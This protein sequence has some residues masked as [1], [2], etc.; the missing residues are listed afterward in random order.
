MKALFDN[1]PRCSLTSMRN[2]LL[3][4]T[5]FIIDSV[6]H[7]RLADLLVH[8]VAITSFNVEELLHVTRHLHDKVKEALRHFF[9]T[10]KDIRI[11]EIPVHPGDRD[12][13][14]SFVAGVDERLL[15]VVADPSDAVLIATAIATKSDVLTKDKH[16]L[17]TVKLENFLK[18]YG[19]NVWKEAKDVVPRDDLTNN[20]I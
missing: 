1:L 12:S 10:H 18:E 5:C 19:I 3:L 11:L 14:H 7:H 8:S 9:N 2:S 15:K 17:F 4:D 20:N 16:H 6:E 13:E